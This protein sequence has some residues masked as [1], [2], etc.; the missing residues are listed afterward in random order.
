M[1]AKEGATVVLT[2]GRAYKIKALKEMIKKAWVK[3]LA[4][5]YYTNYGAFLNRS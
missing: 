2:F 5:K 4:V 1:F 3:A